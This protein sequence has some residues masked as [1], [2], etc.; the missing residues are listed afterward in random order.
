MLFDACILACLAYGGVFL[1]VRENEWQLRFVKAV[2]LI[3]VAKN[4]VFV[5]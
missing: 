2:S 1:V 4:S 5:I 3:M